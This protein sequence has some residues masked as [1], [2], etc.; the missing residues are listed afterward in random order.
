MNSLAGASPLI[1]SA[2]IVLISAHICTRTLAQE[3]PDIVSIA[4]RPGMVDTPVCSHSR[5]L[6]R[7][8]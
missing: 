7:L 1:L 3:E 8:I 6:L 4:L 2:F 5:L